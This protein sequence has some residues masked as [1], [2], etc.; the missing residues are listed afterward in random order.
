MTT[1]TQTG[2]VAAESVDQVQAKPTADD[3]MESL[4][5]FDEIAIEQAFGDDISRIAVTSVG[6]FGRALGFVLL[7]RG[8]LKDSEAKKQILGLTRAELDDMFADAEG[9]ELP[10]SES[11]KD[12]S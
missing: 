3:V 6:K 1:K 2:D 9:D 7:R 11:G 8:G 10:G 5:G 4:T 12:E